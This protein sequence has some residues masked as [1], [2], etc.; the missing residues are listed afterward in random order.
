MYRAQFRAFVRYATAYLG[1]AQAAAD[2][3]QE[4]VAKAIRERRG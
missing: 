4:G 2:A 3:V 1:D